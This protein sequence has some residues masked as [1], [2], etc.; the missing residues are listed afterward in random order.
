[1]FI[2]RG[3]NP[4]RKDDSSTIFVAYFCNEAHKN[5]DKSLKAKSLE[6]VGYP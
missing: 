6:K 1:M 2:A 4:G 3:I 5:H